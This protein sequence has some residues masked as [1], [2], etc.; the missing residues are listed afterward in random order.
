MAEWRV[1]GFEIDEPFDQVLERIDVE[2]IE[3]I[4]RKIQRHRRPTRPASGPPFS[5]G[6]KFS[7]RWTIWRWTN[8]RVVVDAD[9][10]PE[11]CHAFAR[12]GY[13][14]ACAAVDQPSRR[15]WRP[16][17]FLKCPSMAMRPS[18]SR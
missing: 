1:D 6:T 17:K 14:A 18:S 3:I 11:I 13:A 10:P 16:R 15:S 5:I 7:R 4:W 9:G 12:L 2:R 8:G